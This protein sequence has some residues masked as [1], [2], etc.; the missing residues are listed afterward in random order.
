MDFGNI[1]LRVAV[2]CDDNIRV[3]K[4]AES[5]SNFPQVLVK[6]ENKLIIGTEA[7]K[8]LTGFCNNFFNEF[9]YHIL[10]NNSEADYKTVVV[11][12]LK[13]F[14]E[15]SEDFVKR[16]LNK[17]IE[18]IDEI[19]FSV[20]FYDQE[21]NNLW[22]NLLNSCAVEAGFN[23]EKVFFINE[24]KAAIFYFNRNI[25]SNYQNSN[26]CCLFNLG[27]LYF[28]STILDYKGICHRIFPK[29][30]SYD[31]L[32]K[33]NGGRSFFPKLQN[34][35]D[36]KLSEYLHEFLK[37]VLKPEHYNFEE[38]L[39]FEKIFKNNKKY[40]AECY[41]KYHDVLEGFS[42]SIESIQLEFRHLRKAIEP[43][44]INTQSVEN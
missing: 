23:K 41:R 33:S 14:K 40:L 20:P 8:N 1:K 39:N 13:H 22:S 34:L 18:K 9:K 11:S 10:K 42:G 5:Y 6:T 21:N 3:I 35:F 32:G 17:K 15:V 43:I 44:E 36:Q 27:S 12:I 26:G 28:V 2:I 31:E 29:P 25:N 7:E 4:N 16:E 30:P 19:Y 37:D 38:I 24:E